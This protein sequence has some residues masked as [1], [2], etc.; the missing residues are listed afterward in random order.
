[1]EDIFDEP[2]PQ[3]MITQRRVSDQVRS[4]GEKISEEKTF[5]SKVHV[6]VVKKQH[7]K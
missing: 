2:T 3:M 4:W 6:K 1:M 5:N 7:F